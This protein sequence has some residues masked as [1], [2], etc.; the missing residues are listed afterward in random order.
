[1]LR[2]A[3]RSASGWLPRSSS[4]SLASPRLPSSPD[5]GFFDS[6][7]G[8]EAGHQ[9]HQRQ[10]VNGRHSPQ[11][12]QARPEP[13]GGGRG[14]QLEADN[15]DKAARHV[16]LLRLALQVSPAA[17]ALLLSVGTSMLVFPFFT[18]VRSTGLFGEH[19][20]QVGAAPGG[21]GGARG[22]RPPLLLLGA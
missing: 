5:P 11:L 9:Q 13:G 12:S 18:Y 19:L 16:P 3:E 7:L 6:E 2:A 17:L 15:N 4:G 14:S 21:R 22:A 8:D 1:M 10:L 20:P